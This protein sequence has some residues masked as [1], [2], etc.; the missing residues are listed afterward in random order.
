MTE[1]KRCN[2]L[3]EFPPELKDTTSEMAARIYMNR[4][5]FI[6]EAVRRFIYDIKRGLYHHAPNTN[7]ATMPTTDMDKPS[8]TFVRVPDCPPD[9]Y[10]LAPATTKGKTKRA[11]KR[12]RLG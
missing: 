5:E 10:F 12:D 11:Y 7:T 1:S 8:T 3:V 9:S 4:S 2:V 6:R